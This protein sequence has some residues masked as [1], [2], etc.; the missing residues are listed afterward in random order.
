MTLSKQRSPTLP[1]PVK[2]SPDAYRARVK[3]LG[4]TMTAL[5]EYLGITR[6]YLLRRISDENRPRIYTEVLWSLPHASQLKR[7]TEHRRRIVGQTTSDEVEALPSTKRRPLP[8][9]RWHDYL[10]VGALVQATMDVG[11]LAEEGAR[12]IVVSIV[13]TGQAERYGI[14]FENGEFDWFDP[15]HIDQWLADIGLHREAVSTYVFTSIEQLQA[16]FARGMFTFWD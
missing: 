2:I 6:S 12:G 11:S 8:G 14:L 10:P 3:S 4:W 7:I 16:D 9:Y 1:S 15:N 5:A 13:D